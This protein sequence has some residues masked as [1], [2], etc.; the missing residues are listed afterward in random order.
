MVRPVYLQDREGASMIS[1]VS[2]VGIVMLLF[3]TTIVLKGTSERDGRKRSGEMMRI[4]REKWAE[5][6]D[7]DALACLYDHTVRQMYR[8]KHAHGSCDDLV[9]DANLVLELRNS[10]MENDVIREM[11]ESDGEEAPTAD[12]G[13]R[14][15]R[16]AP[17]G[18]GLLGQSSGRSSLQTFL[19]SSRLY[20]RQ[21]RTK[22]QAE[23]RDSL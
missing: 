19:C 15:A 22:P 21:E 4:A 18:S 6:T 13:T 16:R 17:R 14:H 7:L 20:N 12:I 8:L 3:A 5:E 23:G 2:V 11:D 10:I 9:D 1:V